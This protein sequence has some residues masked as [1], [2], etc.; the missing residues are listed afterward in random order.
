MQQQNKD[1]LIS[2]W[3]VAAEA[4]DAYSKKDQ[5]HII[6]LN[7]SEWPNRVWLEDDK[8]G[9]DHVKALLQESATP[10]TFSKWNALEVDEQQEARDLGLTLKSIQ[11][12]MS[13][14]LSQYKTQPLNDNLLFD[15]VNNRDKAILWSDI[16]YQCFA[17][18]IPD[19]IV[20]A[21]MDRV[22]FYL[23]KHRQDTV[24]CVATFIKDNQT[25]IHSLGVPNQ[26]RKQG[27]A[28]NIMHHLLG[29]AKNKGLENAHLQ[30]SLLGLGVYRKIGFEEIFKMCNYRV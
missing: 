5:F 7:F 12:G 8:A 29:E 28:E 3:L 17:Y 2:L 9:T 23:V 20:C 4:L 11:V 18:S 21:I 24:A 15:R 1:N 25:G 6:A 30:S 10:L 19:K 27:I 22:N 13:L 26:F 14:A 16:F